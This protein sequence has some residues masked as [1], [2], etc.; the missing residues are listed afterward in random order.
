MRYLILLFLSG[1]ATKEVGNRFFYKPH[2]SAILIPN[3][4]IASCPG[5]TYEDVDSMSWCVNADALREEEYR[6]KHFV[7]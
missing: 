7:E 6:S 1:C 2:E 4:K 5:P 3:D